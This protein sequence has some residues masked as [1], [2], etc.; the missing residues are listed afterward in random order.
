MRIARIVLWFGILCLSGCGEDEPDQTVTLPT[1]LVVGVTNQSGSG[2]VEVSA[3]ATNAKYIQVFFG[4]AGTNSGTIAANGNAE[5]AYTNA[6]KYTIRVQAHATAD[7]FISETEE[8][9]ITLPDPNVATIPAEGLSSPLMYD[10][11]TLVWQDEFDGTQVNMQNWT[12]ETGGN[13]WGNNELQFYRS[14]NTSLQ[15]GY[16]VITAKKGLYQGSEYTSSRMITKDK[17]SFQ[18]GRVDIRAV[19]PKRQG[20]WPALWML[21][22]NISTVPWPA[23]GEIDIME[24]VGGL[25]RE[26]TVHGT[27][28][29]QSN[30][31]RV[32]YGDSFTLGAGTYNDKFHVF[33]IVWTVTS[34]K[35]YVDDVL[36]NTADT[37]PADLSEFQNQF[38]FIFNIA[39]GGQW[40]GNPNATTVFP[41]HMIVDYIRVFQ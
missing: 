19:L 38:F 16:L 20:I 37:A 30:G 14:N 27:I 6:G 25:G 4:E 11:M 32:M 41:Q 1:D 21:G 24:M 7:V 18:Y 29:W 35:W 40:P 39:V 5:H 34:I 28:H 17:K 13:G 26:N 15:D 9:T 8:V 10:G 36:F 2:K 3:S 23:C 33:S 31:E 22:S 12:F